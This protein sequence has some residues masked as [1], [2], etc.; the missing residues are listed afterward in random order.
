[1]H[2]LAVALAVVLLSPTLAWAVCSG[3]SP[4]GG[5]CSGITASGCCDFQ[6]GG[7]SELLL[8]CDNGTLCQRDCAAEGD[9]FGLYCG[10]DEF[11]N[12]V[13]C[14]DLGDVSSFDGDF[15]Y[16]QCGSGGGGTDPGTELP[17]TGTGLPCGD[18]GYEGCCDGQTVTWCEGG[19]LRVI[20][21]AETPSCGWSSEGYYDCGSTGSAAPSGAYPLNC[22]GT[23]G[24]GPITSGCGSITYEGCCNGSTVAWCEGG[25]VQQIN[26]A[27]EPQ[28]PGT[29]CG[30][31]SEGGYYWCGSSTG[32]DPSGANPRGCDGSGGSVGPCTPDCLGKLCGNDGCGGQCGTCAASQECVGGQCIASQQCTPT[33]KRTDG[34]LKEC[35]DNGCGGMCG[36]CGIGKVCSTV[37]ACVDPGSEGTCDPGCGNRECGPDACGG[38]CGACEAGYGCYDG[39]CV[40]GIECK[41][42]CD[43]RECGPD[44]CE[45]SCGECAAGSS[46]SAD[47]KCVKGATPDETGDCPDGQFL[48]YGVCVSE[49]EA[50]NRDPV[51]EAVDDGTSAGGKAGC[52]VGDAA[53]PVDGGLL[54]LALVVLLAAPRVR[55][56]LVTARRS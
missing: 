26:C 14:G 35:G 21:C 17:G 38:T 1:M 5:S 32:S 15:N 16:V 46:C 2:R 36:S 37:G 24:T 4:A 19:E 3:G 8:W 10:Y 39:F 34:T 28:A 45:G 56:A 12:K 13:T 51:D 54:L 50:D 43:G 22:D 47:A 25:A 48:Y 41:P 53:A 42:A 7:S 6:S 20:D 23:G 49:D 31:D 44:G 30:W 40:F 9:F 29:S 18:I 52:S 27:T 11:Q 55:R 33:C